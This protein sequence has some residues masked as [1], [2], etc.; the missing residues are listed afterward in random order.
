MRQPADYF[1][2]REMALVYI[3]KRLN[4]AKALEDVLTEA[5]FDYAVEPD[6][7]TGGVIFRRQRI[8]AFF[9]VT[10]DT[11]EAVRTLMAQRGY[12]PFQE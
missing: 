10:P 1:G 6:H 8:G 2:D 5:G 7:Y 3:A 11:E 12:Q 4:E 9:Y